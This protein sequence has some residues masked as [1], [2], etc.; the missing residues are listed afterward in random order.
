MVGFE[1]KP[2]G[3]DRFGAILGPPVVPFYLFLGE[4]PYKIRLL[5]KWVP[6]CRTSLLEDLVYTQRKTHPFEDPPIRLPRLDVA[7]PGLLSP[8]RELGCAVGTGVAGRISRERRGMRTKKQAWTPQLACWIWSPDVLGSQNTGEPQTRHTFQRYR[9]FRCFLGVPV[10]CS[11][12]ALWNRQPQK[13]R[14]HLA[15]HSLLFLGCLGMD[16]AH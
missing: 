12:G 14:C 2:A 5:E 13:F 9:P 15:F 8:A 7:S 3:N 10:P 16:E 4:F 11:P 1:G 6:F